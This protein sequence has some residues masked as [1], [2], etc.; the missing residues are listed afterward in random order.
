MSHEITEC[1][2]QFKGVLSDLHIGLVE[3]DFDLMRTS[4][5]RKGEILDQMSSIEILAIG[6][7]EAI[8]KE[9]GEEESEE[10]KSLLL[11]CKE[12]TDVSI[13][14]ARIQNNRADQL[15]ATV[16]DEAEQAHKLY[17][18]KGRVS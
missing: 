4:L 9:V 17:N 11:E 6:D 2:R 12:M 3:V 1:L 18:K 8:L 5:E 14:L 7:I 16:N 13:E 15:I 10:V